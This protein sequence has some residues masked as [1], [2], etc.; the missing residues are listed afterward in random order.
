MEQVML[1]QRPKAR[2]RVSQVGGAPQG[3]EPHEPLGAKG[4]W[5]TGGREECGEPQRRKGW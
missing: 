4:T 5:G 1:E 2:V 3:V